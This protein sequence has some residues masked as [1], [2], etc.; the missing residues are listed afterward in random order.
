MIVIKN[1]RLNL[2]IGPAKVPYRSSMKA[3]KDEVVILGILPKLR[4]TG[5]FQSIALSFDEP[6]TFVLQGP[7]ALGLYADC[8]ISRRVPCSNTLAFDTL[9]STYNTMARETCQNTALFPFNL[10]QS[11]LRRHSTCQ[12]ARL[13]LV[14]IR[15][16]RATLRIQKSCGSQIGK[17]ETMRDIYVALSPD[18]SFI[19]KGAKCNQLGLFP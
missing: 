1:I 13:I 19:P 18:A 5:D 17:V 8:I 9:S 3:P 15:S 10:G 11:S 6:H 14:V 12:P 16:P 7:C 2:M 4:L